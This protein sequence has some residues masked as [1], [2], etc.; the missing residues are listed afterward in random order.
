MLKVE[1]VARKGKFGPKL[2][3]AV[4]KEFNV[5]V[6]NIFVGASEEKHTFSTLDWGGVCVIF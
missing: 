4:S 1:L 2:V 6:N 5:P 3:E